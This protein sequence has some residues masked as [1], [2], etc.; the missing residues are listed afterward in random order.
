MTTLILNK[1]KSH[2][3]Y[4]FSDFRKLFLGRLI[5]AIG[6]KFYMIALAWWI[7]SMDNSNSKM[8]LGLLM[9][10]TSLPV[11]IFGPFLGTLADR[12]NKKYCMLAADLLRFLLLLTLS[13]LLFS[14]NLTMPLLYLISFLTAAFIPLFEASVSSSLVRLTDEE[15]LPGAVAVDSSVMQLSN[16]IGS[17]LGTVL[18]AA[19]GV[20]GAFVWNS[21]S[22][23]ISFIF[24]LMI[25]TKLQPAQSDSE[26]KYTD[27]LKEGFK[28]LF[29]NKPIF[30]LLIFFALLNF[31]AAPFLILIPMI[32]KFNLNESATWLAVFEVFFALGAVI[33]SLVVSFKHKYHNIY[34]LFFSAICVMG[35]ILTAIS[36]TSDK[37][38]IA[39]LIFLNGCCLALTN[40]IAI[41]LFQSIVP[42][43]M[44]GR[45]FALLSTVCFAVMPVAFMLNGFITEIYSVNFSLMFN[46]L[47]SIVLSFVLLFIPKI[48]SSL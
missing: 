8:H 23:L 10:V 21:A 28:Y 26:S 20:I 47:C 14:D 4:L 32:V 38:L 40:A 6:D 18:I 35:A 7:V 48:K 37:Y 13:G 34:A 39:G 17:T 2:P 27:D 19:I 24:V 25:K 11:V 36:F 15:H 1:F 29:Q 5:A 41:T 31:F 44:K 42:D 3:L 30:Y 45:F 16:V 9:G 33:T 22:F 12:F 46:G 43:E